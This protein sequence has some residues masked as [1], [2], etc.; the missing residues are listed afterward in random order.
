MKTLRIT[1]EEFLTI[2]SALREAAA[3]A[4]SESRRGARYDNAEMS[5]HYED[6]ANMIEGLIEKIEG[7]SFA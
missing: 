7:Q 1:F 4:R 3:E 6:H 5:A 2:K